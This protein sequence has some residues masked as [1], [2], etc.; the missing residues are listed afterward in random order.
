MGVV[1]WGVGCGKP[2]KPG[3]YT[4]ITKYLDWIEKYSNDNSIYYLK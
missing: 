2:G 1:S 3:V 4:R